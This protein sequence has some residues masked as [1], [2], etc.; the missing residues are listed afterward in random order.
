[1]KTKVGEWRRIGGRG[2]RG[3]A[4]LRKEKDTGFLFYCNRRRL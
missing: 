2:G 4:S 3:A 1:M